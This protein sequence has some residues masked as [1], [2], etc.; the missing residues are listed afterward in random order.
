MCT[1]YY[2]N[3]EQ[4]VSLN[5]K[6]QKT[7]VSEVRFIMF[8]N[9]EY[10]RFSLQFTVEKKKTTAIRLTFFFFTITYNE[11][12]VKCSS[13]C[14]V[15]FV[16]NVAMKYHR[17]HSGH[18]QVAPKLISSSIALHCNVPPQCSRT[19]KILPDIF[20]QF[21][22]HYQKKNY[23]KYQVPTQPGQNKHCWNATD[24]WARSSSLR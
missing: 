5:K 8:W 10:L 2:E 19:G 18:C 16:F 3:Q 13:V 9:A 21:F 24:E 1:Y 7:T 14:V 4:Y 15:V 22:T 6:K 23:K 20:F 17:I 12:R 11:S